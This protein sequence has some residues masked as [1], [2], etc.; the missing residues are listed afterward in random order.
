MAGGRI[1]IRWRNVVVGVLVGFALMLIALEVY[2]R[3]R[4]HHWAS[5]FRVYWRTANLPLSHVYDPDPISPFAYPPTAVVWLEPLGLLQLWPSYILFTLL[6]IPLFLWAAKQSYNSGA[7]AL[8]LISPPMIWALASGQLLPLLAAAIFLA[9]KSPPIAKGALLAVVMSIKPQLVFLA[10]FMLMRDRQALL[11]FVQSGVGIVAIHLVVWGMQPWI[12]WMASVQ[13][14]ED[15]AGNEGI[16]RNFITPAGW[17]HYYDLPVWPVLLIAT[18]V[19]VWAIWKKMIDDAA[20]LL[21]GCSIFASPYAMPYDLAALM[22]WAATSILAGRTPTAVIGGFIYF[23]VLLPLAWIAQL[24]AS[25]WIRPTGRNS[26]PVVSA[27][28]SN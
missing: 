17:A 21:V 20:A 25:F 10:P 19:S 28:T 7:I 3:F 26:A 1:N 13:R 16:A 14:F 8:S 6:S 22:P 4:F 27:S 5:D 12:D 24:A 23:N 2:R 9:F 18:V 15:V 11:W